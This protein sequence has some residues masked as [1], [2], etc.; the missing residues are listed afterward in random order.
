MYYPYFRG[1][2]Y[3]LLTIRECASLLSQ[4]NF[5]PIIEPV[6]EALNGLERALD[7]IILAQGSS[8]VIL[9]PSKGIHSEDGE[10]IYNFFMEKFSA[11]KGVVA[12]ILLSEGMSLADI[13][14]ILGNLSKHRV[15][16]IHSGFNDV[17]ALK[18]LVGRFSN[19]DSHI[20]IEQFCGKLYQ[21]KFKSDKTV[22]IRNGFKKRP[23][24]REYPPLEFF[25][26]LHAT[27]QEEGVAAFGD[28]LMV[29]D[30]YSEGG[31]PAYAVAIHL[32]CINK[33]E[34]M[35]IHHF[36][37]ETNDTPKDPAK[38]FAEALEK[39]ITAIQFSENNILETEA[40]KEFKELHAKEHFPGLG[41]VKKLSM[42]HHI[43]TLA[44]Y[45]K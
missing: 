21:K 10:A 11:K 34:E 1:K 37:S 3:E 27:Y 28:Y 25:S 2:Q 8:I 31:G 22:L 18:E 44:D 29:G 20:F 4:K 43:E 41:Y 32:T 17:T 26:D 39:L 15:S 19:I 38:K 16:L 33:D 12:G 9:N 30:E 45:V 36:V 35:L 6:K 40:V 13:E 5:I 24:N 42:K 7:A 23:N 14:E